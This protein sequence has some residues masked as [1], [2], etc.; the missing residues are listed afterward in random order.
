MVRLAVSSVVSVLYAVH[1]RMSLRSMSLFFSKQHTTSRPQHQ[2]GPE[3]RPRFSTA[4][5]TTPAANSEPKTLIPLPSPWKTQDSDEGGV[6]LDRPEHRLMSEP[7]HKDDPE[8]LSRGGEIARVLPE[9]PVGAPKSTAGLQHTPSGPWKGN[10]PVPSALPTA[11]PGP[12]RSL[13]LS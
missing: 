3:K 11:L 5:R 8:G 2:S 9:P 4:H 10:A 1:Y 13:F 6:C 7:S 12:V